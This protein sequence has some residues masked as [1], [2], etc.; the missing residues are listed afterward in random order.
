MDQLKQVDTL[1]SQFRAKQNAVEKFKEYTQELVRKQQEFL[2]IIENNFESL[3]RDFYEIQRGPKKVLEAAEQWSELASQKMESFNSTPQE[4]KANSAEYIAFDMLEEPENQEDIIKMGEK[5]LEDLADNSEMPVTRIGD[6]L[7]NLS[8]QFDQHFK[9]KLLVMM[10]VL[11]N[12]VDTNPDTSSNLSVANLKSKQSLERFSMD[13]LKAPKTQT[14]QKTLRSPI[15]PTDQNLPSRTMNAKKQP[16]VEKNLLDDDNDLLDNFSLNDKTES[17]NDLVGGNSSEINFL[18]DIP[19]DPTEHSSNIDPS[20]IGDTDKAYDVISDV[21]EN[22]QTSL[23]LSGRR[24][25]NSFFESMIESIIDFAEG[26]PLSVINLNLSGNDITD[27]GCDKILEFLIIE[28]DASASN[29]KY[30]DLSNNVIKDKS[31]DMIVAL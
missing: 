1:Y 2:H 19:D 22:G 14:T 25:G 15:R 11:N 31:V 7:S 4:V 24:L 13:Q 17:N 28:K 9:S 16:R 3:E 26:E 5:V 12:L 20:I 21:L 29:I 30:V 27:E 6:Q 23:D 8:R 10:D 18:N